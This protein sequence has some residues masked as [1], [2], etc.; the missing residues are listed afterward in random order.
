MADIVADNVVNGNQSMGG[1]PAPIDAPQETQSTS[2]PEGQVGDA[3]ARLTTYQLD[4]S[5]SQTTPYVKPRSR[6]DHTSAQQ[7]APQEGSLVSDTRTLGHIWTKLIPRVLE[8]T[9]GVARLFSTRCSR[10]KLWSRERHSPH[11][12][13]SRPLTCFSGR[14]RPG[15]AETLTHEQWRSESQREIE[16]LQEAHIV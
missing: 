13:L 4:T 10:H 5:Q 9:T 14:C 6:D 8:H 2:R 16:F 7:D 1:G 3:Q 11:H 15:M 12:L